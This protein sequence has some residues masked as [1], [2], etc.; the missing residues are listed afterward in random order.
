MREDSLNSNELELL[1]RFQEEDDVEALSSVYAN[2]MPLVYGVCLKYLKQRACAQDA[3]MDIFEKLLQELKRHDIPD[4][5]RVWLYVLSKNFC[6]MQLRKTTATRKRLEKMPPVFMENALT[7]HPMDRE[8][9]EEQLESLL[10]ECLTRLKEMQRECVTL[11]YYEKYCYREIA[12]Q[13]GGNEKQVKSAI[14]N[15]KRNLKLCL[16]AKAKAK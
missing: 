2:Y 10:A 9:Q 14:Q 15:G 4:N 12:S 8:E 1:Q 11:F 16:E 6:L 5:F 13:L 7:V 3:V